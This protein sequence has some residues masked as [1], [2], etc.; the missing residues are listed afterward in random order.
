MNAIARPLTSSQLVSVAS[1]TSAAKK[2]LFVETTCNGKTGY[3][4]ARCATKKRMMDA[5]QRKVIVNLDDDDDHHDED[6]NSSQDSLG[7]QVSVGS[8]EKKVKK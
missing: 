2:H 1:S 7:S 5:S 4:H 8:P 3:S 6:F